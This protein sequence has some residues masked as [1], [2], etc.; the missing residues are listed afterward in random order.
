MSLLQ[1]SENI[2]YAINPR[3][4]E[5]KTGMWNFKRALKIN[6]TTNLAINSQSKKSY[7]HKETSSLTKN[8][9]AE[10]SP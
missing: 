10:T 4:R 9:Q 8:S 7:I 6:Q 1:E 3:K 5:I 2:Y